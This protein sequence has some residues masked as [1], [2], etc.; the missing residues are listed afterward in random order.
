MLASLGGLAAVSTVLSGLPANF[1]AAVLII[2]HRRREIGEDRLAPLLAQRT[3]LPV[4]TAEHGSPVHSPGVVVLPGG[5][6]P[7]RLDSFGRLVLPANREL[8]PG[9]VL[10]RSLASVW[11]RSVLA[12]VLTGML[13]DGSEGIKMVKGSGGRVLVQ[14]PATAHAPSMPASALATGCV[15]FA[16]PLE[17]ISA[18]LIALTMAPGGADLLAAASTPWARLAG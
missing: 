2:Q 7:A 16:L 18:A 12:V 8:Y 10:L 15:D 4:R 11:G 14:D 5:G 17:R 9:D 13:H 6:C 1:P 3:A